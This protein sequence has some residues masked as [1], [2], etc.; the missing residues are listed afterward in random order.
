MV[1]KS[2]L[3]LR[4]VEGDL[5]NGPH[6]RHLQGALVSHGHAVGKWGAD[7][8]FG[9]DTVA[10]V[11]EFQT[12]HGLIADGIVGPATWGALDALDSDGSRVRRSALPFG[13]SDRRGAHVPPALYSAFRSPRPWSRIEGVTLHQTG[14]LLSDRPT[15]WDSVSAHIGV[16]RG[17]MIVVMNELV[18]FIWHGQGLSHSTIGIEICGNFHGLVGQ[19]HTVWKGG[20]GPHE[21]TAAQVSAL[22]G[23]LFP[24]LREQ[25]EDA[26]A[27]WKVV[28]AHRQSYSGRRSDPGEEIWSKIGLN[29]I[30]RLGIPQDPEWTSGSGRPI[31]Q[32]WGGSLT[33]KF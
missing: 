22:N 4:Y 8:W 24:W 23:R 27:E 25:F 10:A 30:R 7:G 32:E 18:D 6:V 17:G 29:W 21:L 3:A 9:S 15:R 16:T 14:C 28:R 11:K 20:G 5:M 31:P 2:A 1:I 33:S 19:G 12:R 13:V 26:G